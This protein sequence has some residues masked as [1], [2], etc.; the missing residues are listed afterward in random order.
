MIEAEKPQSL[1]R[2]VERPPILDRIISERISDKEKDKLVDELLEKFDRQDIEEIKGGEIELSPRQKEL[3]IEAN[4]LISKALGGIGIKMKTEIKY[5]NIHILKADVFEKYRKKKGIKSES[6]SAWTSIG[7]QAI[8]IK[9]EEYNELLFLDR[10]IHE[11]LHINSFI[12]F[13]TVDMALDMEDRVGITERR[14]GLRIRE[15]K[16]KIKKG[17]K[18]KKV[19]GR[20]FFND[21]D[22][23]IIEKLTLD[24]IRNF[25]LKISLGLKDDF[26]KSEKLRKILIDYIQKMFQERGG[27]MSQEELLEIGILYMVLNWGA[28]LLPEA[29]GFLEKYNENHDRI[30][31]EQAISFYSDQEAS[32]FIS[33]FAYGSQRILLERLINKIF[34]KNKEKFNNPSEIAQLFI[35]AAFEGRLLPLARLIDETFGKGSFRKLGEGEDITAVDFSE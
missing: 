30:E 24:I 2:K 29:G 34:E 5:P 35:R 12:S 10:I 23:A 3:I 14:T 22:E 13:Q 16:I 32:G 19:A 9:Q 27:N 18:G 25:D 7:E 28:V 17:K 8:F 15:T 4:R 11:M 33:H 26:Q 31:L 1:V 20:T 6:I 21:L